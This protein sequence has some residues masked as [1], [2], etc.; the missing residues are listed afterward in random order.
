MLV[1]ICPDW[2]PNRMCAVTECRTLDRQAPLC[3]CVYD[4]VHDAIVLM[5]SSNDAIELMHGVCQH[6]HTVDAV[7]DRV[8]HSSSS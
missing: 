2:I 6:H 3:Y 1:E 4:V 7:V 8:R 5:P